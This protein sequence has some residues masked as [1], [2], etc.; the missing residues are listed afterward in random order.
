MNRKGLIGIGIGIGVVAVCITSCAEEPLKTR[1]FLVGLSFME[2]GAGTL[3]N[4]LDTDKDP[5]NDWTN[6]DAQEKYKHVAL[7][8]CKNYKTKYVALTIEVNT[9]YQHPQGSKEDFNRSVKFY[10]KGYDELKKECPDTKIFVTFQLEELKGRGDA[11]WGYDVEPAWELLELFD[12]RLD[13]IAFT[14]YPFPEYT[15]PEDIPD[16][17]YTR[18]FKNSFN[19]I[20]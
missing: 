15:V 7:T 17:Y 18:L 6:K 12:G 11:S 3:T 10:I 16:D 19:I 5:T 9:Y 2:H 4:C 13:V 20:M 1:S 8:L 14:T